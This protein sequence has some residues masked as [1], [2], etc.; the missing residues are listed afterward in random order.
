MY[1]G[2]WRRGRQDGRGAWF[3]PRGVIYDGVWTAGRAVGGAVH[4]RAACSAGPG[5]G[6]AR[7]NVLI[8][9]HRPP[10]AVPM[11]HDPPGDVLARLAD[12][13]L[14][15]DAAGLV[16][17]AARGHFDNVAVRVRAGCD[18]NQGIPAADVA[19][20]PWYA[21]EAAEA[22]AGAAAER[23]M[24]GCYPEDGGEATRKASM[25]TAAASAVDIGPVEAVCI[26]VERLR[27]DH[28]AVWADWAAHSKSVAN[29]ESVGRG[30]SSDVLAQPLSDVSTVNA[31]AVGSFGGDAETVA[32]GQDQAPGANLQ[33]KASAVAQLRA[34][35]RVLGTLERA[36]A[37]AGPALVSSVLRG[38]AAAV[39]ILAETFPRGRMHI[40]CCAAG[41][42]HYPPLISPVPLLDFFSTMIFCQIH[43]HSIAAA[44][45]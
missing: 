20:E 10:A 31:S 24:G 9:V 7:R 32:G 13:E 40:W 33:S 27:S 23:Q 18:V 8:G 11:Q 19:D 21:G 16:R 41:Q 15:A 14:R 38:R 22:A 44:A 45:G 2:E 25:A 37:D 30:V 43:R 39:R 28:P 42:C 29:N 1:Q 36:G 5:V 35:R 17:A 3:G 4:R 26:A 34:L 6:G 12:A